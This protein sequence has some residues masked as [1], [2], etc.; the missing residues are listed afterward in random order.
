METFLRA[1]ANAGAANDPSVAVHLEDWRSEF[2]AAHTG[3]NQASKKTIFNRARGELVAK[4]FLSVLND[5]Y[6][7][8]A[9]SDG[10]S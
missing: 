1:K 7:L 4:G 8:S 5:F 2:Y 6:R 10:N 9:V 3:D